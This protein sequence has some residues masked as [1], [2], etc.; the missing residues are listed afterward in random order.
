PPAH[1]PPPQLFTYTRTADAE[2]RSTPVN[3][4]APAVSSFRP[5]LRAVV[6]LGAARVGAA[7]PR[8]RG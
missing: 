5:Q 6:P 1:H 7:A 8:Q 3:P 2:G 4:R